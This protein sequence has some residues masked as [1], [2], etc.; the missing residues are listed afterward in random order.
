[1]FLGAAALS[2]RAASEIIGYRIFT[3]RVDSYHLRQEWLVGET[4]FL[5]V[6]LPVY[7]ICTGLISFVLAQ[8]AEA[9]QRP[10]ISLAV[11][12]YGHIRLPEYT[13]E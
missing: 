9:F 3:A 13:I 8:L 11:D 4:V 1:M 12:R 2:L 5:H 6:C 10:T 7:V